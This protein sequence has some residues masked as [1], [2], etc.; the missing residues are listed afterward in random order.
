VRQGD[1]LSPMLFLLAMEPLHML[2]QKAQEAHLLQRLSPTCDS[3]RVS[4][5]ADDAAVFVHPNEQDLQI[6]DCILKMFAEASGLTTNMSKTHYY[7]IRCEED[8]MHFLTEAGRSV[9]SFPCSYLG[10][11]LH[12]RKPSK[13]ML[14]PLILK[15]ASRLPG[16]K[17]NFLTYPG[18]E[19]LVKTVLTTMPTYFI[20]VFKPAK[21]LIA[22]IDK[23]RRSFL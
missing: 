18:R 22:G 20:T 17:K 11:P 3:F 12:F 6:T 14:Q 4:L 9:S 21:W 1:L 23:F 19:L 2:F 15:I 16:W 5:Y 13:T 10:L 7:P 8:D